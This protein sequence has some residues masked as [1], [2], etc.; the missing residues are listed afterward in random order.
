M[1]VE[2]YN[3]KMHSIHSFMQLHQQ[4][5]FVERATTV[6]YITVNLVVCCKIIL[7]H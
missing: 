6:V 5:Q 4:P 3:I 7:K 2:V 1:Q